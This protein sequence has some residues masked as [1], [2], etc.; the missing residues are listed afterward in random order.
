MAITG[1]GYFAR[2][3]AYKIQHQSRHGRLSRK[4]QIKI[5]KLELKQ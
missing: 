5:F 2:H 1:E 3:T 4:M